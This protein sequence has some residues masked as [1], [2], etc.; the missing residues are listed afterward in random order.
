[1]KVLRSCYRYLLKA[2]FIFLSPLSVLNGIRIL[3]CNPK[4]FSNPIVMV[5][6]YNVSFG[7][8]ISTTDHISRLVSPSRVS[9]IHLH[10]PKRN[11]T[12][13][14]CWKNVDVFMAYG[15]GYKFPL[16]DERVLSALVKLVSIL[17]PKFVY[18]DA[19]HLVYKTLSQ[20]SEA[21][22]VG[23]EKRT[24]LQDTPVDHTGLRFL[25]EHNIGEG[26]SLPPDEKQ[27]VEEELRRCY[28]AFFDKPFVCL[29]LRGK[30]GE[31][32]S[33]SVRN[34]GDHSTYVDAV[35]YLVNEGFHVLGAGEC[36]HD[37]F[38]GIEGYFPLPKVKYQEALN[39][40]S[41]LCPVL[42]VGQQSGPLL[43]P[44]SV[45]IPSVITEN[46]PYRVGTL[47]SRDIILFK[48]I[49]ID[50][51]Y[52]SPRVIFEKYPELAYGGGFSSVNATVGVNES[53]DITSVVK[54]GVERLIN[55][56]D[57]TDTEA[58]QIEKFKALYRP[59]M[60]I[61]TYQNPPALCQVLK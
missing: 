2:V 25:Y 28:P 32:F 54:E 20:S 34:P 49:V 29:H 19:R 51:K 59:D 44:G 10:H 39:L 58:R 22:K 3:V 55:G 11:K 15:L 26:P 18:V 41:L 52:V 61:Y 33:S 5:G 7:H 24:A 27:A 40:Y 60:P 1:M 6:Y 36:D 35:T 47:R 13:T 43:I 50:G 17:Y 42:Y 53:D 46:F 56:K 37:V 38:K 48:P 8:Q 14:K 21:L 45:N 31:G 9:I 30:G 16:A 12:L 23:S 4:I 57:Y